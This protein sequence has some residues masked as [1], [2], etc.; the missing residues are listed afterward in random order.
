MYCNLSHVRVG[1]GNDLIGFTDV[2]EF[3]GTE[4]LQNH[5]LNFLEHFFFYNFLY[6]FFTFFLSL[7]WVSTMEIIFKLYCVLSKKQNVCHMLLHM[8][9]V[10]II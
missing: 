3:E 4:M 1:A 5:I 2:F 9:V 7:I 10:D 8:S 6:I